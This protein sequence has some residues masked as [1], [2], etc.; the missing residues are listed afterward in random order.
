MIVVLAAIIGG[1]SYRQ[2][3]RSAIARN[4]HILTGGLVDVGGYRLRIDCQGSGGPTVVMD[5]GLTFHRHTWD[6]VAPQVAAFTRVCTYDRAG[7]GQSDPAPTPRTSQQVVDD[8]RTLLARAG[9]PGPYV[10][11]GHSVG[12]LNVQFFARQNPDQVIGLVLV[13]S[14][15]EDQ[16]SRFSALLPARLRDEYLR[17]ENGGNPE[18]LDI[19][20]SSDLMRLAP[21]LRPMPVVVLTAGQA[22]LPNDPDVSIE[23][24]ARA[25]H[26]MQADLARRVP[27]GEQIIAERSGHFIQDD[28]PG[29]VVEAIRGVVERARRR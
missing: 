9:V 24:M 2:N 25:R 18:G 27:G 13:D 10:L 16:A 28:E 15:H 4:W 12:G 22:G 5:S 20:R 7:L 6:R 17:V 19:V 14:S 26:E 29:L 23:Q 11:V 3:L 8:L 1:L 21:P